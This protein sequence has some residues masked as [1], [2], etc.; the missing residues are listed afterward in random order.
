VADAAKAEDDG[1][2]VLLEDFDGVEDVEQDDDD[3]DE[4]G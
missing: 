3:G 4:E 2:L 1:A